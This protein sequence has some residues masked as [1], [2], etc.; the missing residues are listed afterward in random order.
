MN[1]PVSDA[2]QARG[3]AWDRL[4]YVKKQTNDPAQIAK[5]AADLDDAEKKKMAAIAA[6]KARQKAAPQ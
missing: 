3:A 1:D 2:I 4:R 5:A 6:A